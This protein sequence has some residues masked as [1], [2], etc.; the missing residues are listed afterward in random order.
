MR[1]EA[2]VRVWLSLTALLV[3]SAT[4]SIIAGEQSL[5]EAATAA[6]A[7]ASAIV[8]RDTNGRL[9]RNEA[10]QHA[11]EAQTGYRH[12]RPGYVVD[13]IKPLACGGADTPGSM[14]WQTIEA[15]KA[16][17]KVERLGCR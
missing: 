1:F 5:V 16:K 7:A 10:A 15:A 14:Q 9:Q 12:G 11:L 3:L 13:H 2:G 4:S 8:A 6:K 17:D